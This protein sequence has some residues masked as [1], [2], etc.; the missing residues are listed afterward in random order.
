M[1]EQGNPYQP[2]ETVSHVKPARKGEQATR[3]AR[4]LAAIL[5]GLLIMVI[6]LPMQWMAGV[7]DG[8]PEFAEQGI[9]NTILWSIAGFALTLALNGYLLAT[10]AQSIGKLALGIKIIMLDGH[11]ARLSVIALRRI[12]PFTALA[13][14]PVAGPLAGLVDILFI[15]GER[16]RCIHDRIAGTRVVYA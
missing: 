8:F 11:N 1:D 15:F 13:V 5:D 10:R 12:L 7:F 4:L 14:V 9:G 6:M 16:Q 3:G 2:P